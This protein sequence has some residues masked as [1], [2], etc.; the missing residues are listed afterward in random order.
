MATE[1]FGP[2][3]AVRGG[4]MSSQWFPSL[5]P[6][7]HYARRF[8]RTEP[9]PDTGNEYVIES[10]PVI[11]YVQEIAQKGKGSSE[12]VITGEFENRTVETLIMSVND[13]QNYASEDKIIVDPV[14]ENGVYVEGTGRAYWING[15]PNDQRNGPF[16]TTWSRIFDGFGGVIHLKRVT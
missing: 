5:Y 8:S 1:G 14:I 6:V 16:W 11:R 7:V 9:D 4:L 2:V 10:A 12:D 3:S 15:E 13:P